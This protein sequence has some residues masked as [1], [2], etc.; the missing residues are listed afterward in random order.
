MEKATAAVLREIENRNKPLLV[1]VDGR[2]ASG[3]TTFAAALERELGCAVIHTDHFFLRPEQRTEERLN[4]AGGNVDYERLREEVM[5]PLLTG[6]PFSYRKFD[7]GE[8]KLS[9]KIEVKPTTVT[10][11]EGSYSCCPA[12]WE[13]YGLRIFLTVDPQ[14]QLRRIELRNGNEAAVK[15]RE[16][17]IPL[18]EKYF[19]ACKIR[20]RCDLVFGSEAL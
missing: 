14:E 12:L 19:A 16:R 6:K 3:K 7:C 20:E 4:E 9:A 1:A 18:E 5:L 15:F 13:Y 2:C 17:W 10:V 11:I 8:M